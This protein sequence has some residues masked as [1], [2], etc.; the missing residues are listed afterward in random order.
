MAFP[1]V[2]SKRPHARWG[3]GVGSRA[4]SYNPKGVSRQGP[5]W[6]KQAPHPP[7]YT[8]YG[9]E[10]PGFVKVAPGLS[11]DSPT[12]YFIPRDLFYS[13]RPPCYRSNAGRGCHDKLV[14]GGLVGCCGVGVWAPAAAVRRLHIYLGDR[15]GVRAGPSRERPPALR[16]WETGGVSAGRRTAAEPGVRGLPEAAD[17]LPLLTLRARLGLCKGHRPRSHRSASSASAGAA[18]AST[19]SNTAHPRVT[20]PQSPYARATLHRGSARVG[21]GHPCSRGPTGTST[22][23]K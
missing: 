14:L 17:V 1:G 7:H 19:S 12:P 15:C 5:L 11:Q 21:A 6:G 10:G 13:P 22:P 9:P 20:L 3:N 8:K 4:A 2:D 16:K 18:N 23:A